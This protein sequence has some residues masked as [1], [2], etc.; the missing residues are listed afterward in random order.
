LITAIAPSSTSGIVI[1][2]RGIG[3]GVGRAR[4]D[5]GASGRLGGASA[6][7]SAGRASGASQGVASGTGTTREG[8]NFSLAALSSDLGGSENVVPDDR[9]AIA[10]QNLVDSWRTLLATVDGVRAAED[11]ELLLV[12]S[13]IPVPFF[14]PVFVKRIPEDPDAALGRIAAFFASGEPHL[15]WA[16]GAIDA[17]FVTAAEARGYARN[18]GPPAMVMRPPVERSVSTSGMEIVP[19][20]ARDR[21]DVTTVIS[22]GFG[23]P[24]DLSERVFSPAFFE[25][26]EA[27][28]LL[29]RVDGVAVSTATLL[30]TGSVGGVYNVATPEVHRGKGYGATLTQAVVNEGAQRGCEAMTLQSSAMGYRIYERMGFEPVGGYTHLVKE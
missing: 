5:S 10:D 30:V 13:G 15:V 4:S 26:A 17:R 19:A 1:G 16:P 2:R 8:T 7:A 29:G 24:V 25:L 9:T 18:D 12:A 21:H 14:N 28:I 22:E 11:D 3:D 23:L 20:T 6:P 27:T